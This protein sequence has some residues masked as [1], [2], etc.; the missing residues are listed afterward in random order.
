MSVP[1]V[2]PLDSAPAVV[3][4]LTGLLYEGEELTSAMIDA[5]TDAA[6][7]ERVWKKVQAK[8]MARSEGSSVEDRKGDA[9]VWHE[10]EYARFLTTKAYHEALVERGRWLRSAVAAAQTILAWERSQAE[11]NNAG[12]L[13]PNPPMRRGGDPGPR[14]PGG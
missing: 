12:D 10:A 11:M 5:A 9:L 1:D 4:F 6:S 7:A 14:E 13:V 2:P 3:A 8:A